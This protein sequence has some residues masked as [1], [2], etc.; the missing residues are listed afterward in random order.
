[1][2]N[3]GNSI[4]RRAMPSDLPGLLLWCV[5]GM[6]VWIAGFVLTFGAVCRGRRAPLLGL[7]L[8]PAGGGFVL[9]GGLI[10]I[11]IAAL[12]RWGLGVALLIALTTCWAPVPFFWLASHIHVTPAD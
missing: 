2:P 6:A 4:Y 3:Q 10:G 5:P 7:R 12:E 11:V 8:L 9:V 1:M